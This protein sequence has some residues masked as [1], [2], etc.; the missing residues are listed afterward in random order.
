MRGRERPEGLDKKSSRGREARWSLP[1]PTQDGGQV[2]GSGGSDTSVGG[3]TGLEQTVDT[4]HREL[5]TGTSGT[6]DG[7]LLVTLLLS[8]DGTLGT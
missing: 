2:H 4:T 8:V 1:P 7:L 3:H 6:R 5:Q